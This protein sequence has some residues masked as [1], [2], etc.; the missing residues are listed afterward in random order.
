ML[1][2]FGVEVTRT[3]ESAGEVYATLARR[4][5]ARRL[6]AVHRGHYNRMN[7]G[8]PGDQRMDGGESE[9]VGW[10]LVGDIRRSGT[11]SGRH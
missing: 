10:A 4:K 9:G 11:G 8:A 2:A 3:F 6:S 1:C 7:R 5:G